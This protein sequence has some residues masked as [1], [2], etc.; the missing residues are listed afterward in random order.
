MK[1]TLI[2]I[3][4]FPIVL[5]GQGRVNNDSLVIYFGEVVNEYR[6]EH[7]LSSLSIEKKLEGFTKEWCTHMSGTRVVNHGIGEYSFDNRVYNYELIPPRTYCLENCGE[8]YCPDEPADKD[9]TF[10]CSNKLLNPYINKMMKWECSQMEYAEYILL[11]WK[12]SPPHNDALLSSRIA[13]FYISSVTSNGTIYF[14][15][16]GT[17]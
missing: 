13:K 14:S 6:I 9:I 11:L 7:G 5:L 15:F 8:G 4:L 16:I 3:F 1:H 12:L 2:S 10:S 17:N